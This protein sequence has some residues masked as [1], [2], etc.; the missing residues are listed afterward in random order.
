MV[1]GDLQLGD[2]VGSRIESPGRDLFICGKL[3]KLSHVQFIWVF[4]CGKTEK[5]HGHIF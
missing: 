3:G 5:N 4:F 1:V 2:Q